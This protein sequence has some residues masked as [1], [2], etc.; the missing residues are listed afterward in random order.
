MLDENQLQLLCRYVVVAVETVD[1][2]SIKV[3]KWPPLVS[4]FFPADGKRTLEVQ[5]A[6]EPPSFNE[7]IESVKTAYDCT[8]LHFDKPKIY[9]HDGF[10]VMP[11]TRE[12]DFAFCLNKFK[13]NY[14]QFLNNTYINRIYVVINR[15]FPSRL[16]TEARERAETSHQ[17][18][19]ACSPEA[20]EQ[21]P[22]LDK[23][24]VERVKKDFPKVFIIEGNKFKCSCGYIGALNGKRRVGNIKRH[25]ATTCHDRGRQVSR[26]LETYFRS[27]VNTNDNFQQSQDD[28]E[29]PIEL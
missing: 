22:K 12:L 25:V 15:K 16:A 28:N 8:G 13:S 17:K 7:F 11:V 6:G 4:G 19:A 18:S 10:E 5:M 21:L 27:S 24:F 2:M 3:L 26:T 29:L 9:Y 14:V 23:E 1:K 20:A